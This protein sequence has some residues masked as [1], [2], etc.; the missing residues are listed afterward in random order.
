LAEH[1]E[2]IEH[3][4][5]RVARHLLTEQS[6]VTS[7]MNEWHA[8]LEGPIDDL[9]AVLTTTDERAT[10]LRQSMPFAGAIPEEERLAIIRKYAAYE[11]NRG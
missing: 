11:T 3:A 10:R 4:R 7:T 6:G 5:L 1:P 8:L 9:I 2:W